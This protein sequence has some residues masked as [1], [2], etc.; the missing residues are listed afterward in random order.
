MRFQLKLIIISSV[1]ALVFLLSGGC[2]ENKHHNYVEQMNNKIENIMKACD[3]LAN[4]SLCG[5]VHV[6][7]PFFFIEGGVTGRLRKNATI[8][9]LA[10]PRTDLESALN[11]TENCIPIGKQQ[12]DIRNEFSF[13]P[14]P[15]GLYIVHVPAYQFEEIQG[16]P[17]VKE[18]NQSNYTLKMIFQG[19]DYQHSL[20]AFSITPTEQG[21]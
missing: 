8:Y 1:F 19:G 17:V 20:A 12:L 15:A 4:E 3:K 18:F 11:T 9:L 7:E 5:V 13:G 2:D 21:G 14:I 6:R 10:T 16:F